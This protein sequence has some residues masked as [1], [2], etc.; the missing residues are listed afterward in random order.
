[1]LPTLQ[2]PRLTLVPATFADIDR[3]HALMI[4]PDVRRYLCDD[5][6]MSRKEIR[7]LLAEGLAVVKEGMGFW[8]VWERV[9]KAFIGLLSL[10]VVVDSV[11]K[12]EPRL[13]G[14]YEPA[15]AFHPSRF[16]KGLAL[17]ATGRVIDYGFG[18]LGFPRLA[19]TADVPN[20]GSIKLAESLGFKRFSE[21]RGAVYPLCHFWLTREDWLRQKR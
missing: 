18:V 15:M 20:K 12:S 14:E 11:V 13:T 6:I 5:K 10:Q 3:T 8:T 4:L 2:T 19:W 9:S 7:D 21:T 16:G 1:M 17:E